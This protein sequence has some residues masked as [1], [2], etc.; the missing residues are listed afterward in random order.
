MSVMSPAAVAA[1]EL[2]VRV[3]EPAAVA[4]LVL[5]LVQ[6]G[7]GRQP[8]EGGALLDVGPPVV[9]LHQ[10]GS[11]AQVKRTV[12]T[13]FDRTTESQIVVGSLKSS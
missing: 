6:H 7:G 3:V 4:H 11:H 5:P 2:C 10:V 9:G 13:H 1:V 12:R 8:R